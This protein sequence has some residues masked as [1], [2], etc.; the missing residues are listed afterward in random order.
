MDMAIEIIEDMEIETK[1]EDMATEVDIIEVDIIEVDMAIETTEEDMEEIM[2]I[3]EE[4]GHITDMIEMEILSRSRK[5]IENCLWVIY[6]M[7][8]IIMIFKIL[9]VEKDTDQETFI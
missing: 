4:M 2:E 5:T 6:P 7:I 8:V 1:E 3:I 9:L